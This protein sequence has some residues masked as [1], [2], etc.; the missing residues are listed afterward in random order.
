MALCREG[1]LVRT[2][3]AHGRGASGCGF[4]CRKRP[5]RES[6]VLLVAWSALSL[7]LRGDTQ[8][9][10][11]GASPAFLRDRA[12]YRT[13]Q[14]RSGFFSQVAVWQLFPALPLRSP[15]LHS[16]ALRSSGGELRGAPLSVSLHG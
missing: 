1:A 6:A 9:A 4:R 7:D 13:S 14:I 5:G 10:F 8:W 11:E 3:Q 2:G 16:I 12:T 15:P